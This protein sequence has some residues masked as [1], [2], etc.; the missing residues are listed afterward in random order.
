MKMLD[1]NQNDVDCMV[2]DTM[3]DFRVHQI[4][5]FEF[6]PGSIHCMAFGKAINKLALS[7]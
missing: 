7:R 2:V 4:R 5:F 6:V 3:G 1:Y